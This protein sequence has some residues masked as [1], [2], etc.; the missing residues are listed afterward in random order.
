MRQAGYH[1][2]QERAM[3]FLADA[4]SECNVL[5]G[6]LSLILLHGVLE[7]VH[8]YEEDQHY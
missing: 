2:F 5:F 1:Y 3:A 8:K 6:S 7:W 4:I